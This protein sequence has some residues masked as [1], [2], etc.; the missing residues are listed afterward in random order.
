MKDFCIYCPFRSPSSGGC[1]QFH[2]CWRTHL[3]CS[4]EGVVPTD[5]V[6]CEGEEK[7]EAEIGSHPLISF[8]LGNVKTI[9]IRAT[10]FEMMIK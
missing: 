2:S 5:A 6:L 9:V 8:S 7:L 1:K 3:V 10:D 4:Q